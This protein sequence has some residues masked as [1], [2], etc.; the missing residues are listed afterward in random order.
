MVREIETEELM[1]EA[2]KE[3]LTLKRPLN[4]GNVGNKYIFATQLEQMLLNIKNVS[5]QLNEK[6][7]LK[8]RL[9]GAYVFG[10]S[11][12]RGS[13]KTSFLNILK[14]QL[15]SDEYKHIKTLGIIDPS[16]ISKSLSLIE[17]LVAKIYQD[18]T[19]RKKPFDE[20]LCEEVFY[21]LKTVIR[22]MANLKG[23]RE[24][25]YVD[26]P[27]VEILEKIDKQANFEVEVKKLVT[28]YLAFDH[29]C[30]NS[31]SGKSE[32]L[33]VL[34]L[35]DLDM[36]GRDAISCMLEDIRKYLPD[37][38]LAILTYRESQLLSNVFQDKL[39]ENKQL[40]DAKEVTIGDV[41]L[42]SVRYLEKLIPMDFRIRLLNQSELHAQPIVTLL[43]N[44]PNTCQRLEI[45]DGCQQTFEEFVADF[46]YERSRI[47]INPISQKERTGHYLP[48]NLR[49]M[50][51]LLSVL[52]TMDPVDYS[53]GIDTERKQIAQNV[54]IFES[55]FMQH[56]KEVLD[57]PHSTIIEEWENEQMERK[58][59]YI[60]H[61]V[62]KKVLA[63]EQKVQTEN[64]INVDKLNVLFRLDSS[65]METYNLTIANVY[66]ILEIYKD[67]AKSEVVYTFVYIVKILYSIK[68]LQQV[69]DGYKANNF[70]KYQLFVG[71][72]IIPDNFAY[73]SRR[74]SEDFYIKL[75]KRRWE[76]L[77]Q[78]EHE[79]I[80]KMIYTSAS[81]DSGLRTSKDGQLSYNRYLHMYNIDLRYEDAKFENIPLDPFAIVLKTMYLEA[82][83]QY[84][85][86]SMFDIDIIFRANF[87][88]D[89]FE[90]VLKRLNYIILYPSYPAVPDEKSLFYAVADQSILEMFSNQIFRSPQNSNCNSLLYTESE[91]G[92][93]D[94]LFGLGEEVDIVRTDI[95]KSKKEVIRFVQILQNKIGDS[96]ILA[97]EKPDLLYQLSNLLMALERPRARVSFTQREEIEKIENAAK[98]VVTKKELES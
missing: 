6:T 77:G 40:L 25:F 38:V 44:C 28:S 8:D 5:Q 22:V 42:Q 21:N 52:V 18:V 29:T 55:Y 13:G 46:I 4:S 39:A 48:E 47:R 33:L 66:S 32:K 76:Q 36:V 78:E 9:T 60:Y 41:R 12:E 93:I 53:E 73:L 45:K 30:S 65:L 82:P 64:S 71:G 51:Q 92:M 90:D 67:T 37:N 49:G 91:A 17:I 84:T 50:I 74:T 94:S 54:M 97:K 11:G 58:H 68:L 7:D 69:L 81:R 1:Q 20:K 10:L 15:D 3:L 86:Y 85:F 56:S 63:I 57:T 61:E 34:L 70:E 72:K 80:G 83:H 98:V 87:G 79:L 59:F 23:G 2:R 14:A 26:I 95:V 62:R 43:Q 31:S 96:T 19:N 35:D 24:N 89:S 88:R 75:S 27:S 16:G